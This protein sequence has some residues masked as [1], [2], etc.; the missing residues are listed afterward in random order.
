MRKILEI[1]I[2]FAALGHIYQ[3]VELVSLSHGYYPIHPR[4]LYNE[5]A[6]FAFEAVNEW[7]SFIPAEHRTSEY[8]TQLENEDPHSGWGQRFE[9]FQL[10]GERPPPLIRDEAGLK[11]LLDFRDQEERSVFAYTFD[12]NDEWYMALHSYG[13]VLMAFDIALSIGGHEAEVTRL[14]EVIKENLELYM[15]LIT[16]SRPAW[17][18]LKKGILE[19][20]GSR[21]ATDAEFDRIKKVLERRLESGAQR[22]FKDKTMEELVHII[23]QN[24]RRHEYEEGEYDH[25]YRT[26]Q[27]QLNS[28]GND[29][30]LH[31]P[32]SL[33]DIEALED[34]LGTPLPADYKEFLLITDG[35]NSIW[36]GFY[37]ESF[38]TS[39][40]KV[41][42]AREI[43][44]GNE[45][46]FE[47]LRWDELPQDFK[48]DWPALDFQ[49]I[50]Q[51]HDE[52]Y[53]DL[54][55]TWLVK[56]ELVRKG[57]E[58]FQEAFQKLS[59]DDET[60]RTV[61]R[62]VKDNYGGMEEFCSM[63]WGLLRWAS[64]NGIYAWKNFRE[65]VETLA[66]ES[67]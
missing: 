10:S 1:A 26:D 63:E 7:P 25:R 41:K 49:H 48:V 55:E 42:C 40:S 8:L 24:T 35:M 29:S 66:V 33:H 45:Y 22:P 59:L 16:K 52:E 18:I 38:T 14:I 46:P 57:V 56:P 67:E 43:D 54:D 36:N 60:K 28:I 19:L 4:Y 21:N 12:G 3:S 9:M 2:R 15:P 62:V 17:S 20:D 31:H 64:E 13:V 65:F 58:M 5:G 39:I 53:G 11:R 50:I 34:R 23:D 37:K 51:L 27:T 30:L 6:Y 61:E 47:L 44:P 32:A